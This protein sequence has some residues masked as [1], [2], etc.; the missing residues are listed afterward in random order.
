MLRYFLGNLALIVFACPVS[1]QVGLL[2]ESRPAEPTIGAIFSADDIEFFEK[3]VRPIL[4]NRC[5]ECH[6]SKMAQPKGGLRLDSRAAAIRGGDTGSSVAPGNAKGSLLIDAINYGDLYQMP[7]KNRLPPEEIAILTKWVTKGAPWSKEAISKAPG[8]SD[9]NLQN[10]RDSHWAWR[11]ITHAPL[12]TVADMVWPQQPCDHFVL[13]QLEAR[14]LRPADAASRSTLVRRASFDLLGL[15]PSTEQ[16]EAFVKDDRPDAW[17]RLMDP[18]LAS[19]RMGERWARHW[20]DLMRYAETCGHEFDYAIRNAFYY[21]D[22]VIRAFNSDLPFDQFA[23]EHIAG[24]LLPQ[25]R[26]HPTQGYNES[27]LGTTSWYLGE[28]IHA[29]VD[30]RGD[31]ANRMENQIDVFSKTF[32]GMTVACARCHDHK[33]DAISQKDYY[34]LAGF[35]R[36]S[37]R[38]ETLLDPHGT[39]HQIAHQMRDVKKN[40]D[41]Q[42]RSAIPRDTTV[43]RSQ[44]ASYLRAAMD[45]LQKPRSSEVDTVK[46][47]A[48]KSGLE[49]LRLK[50]WIEA[51]E[52]ESVRH[53]SHPLSL[54]VTALQAGGDTAN[55]LERERAKLQDPRLVERDQTYPLF[56]T[57][58]GPSWNDWFASGEAFGAGPTQFDQW[59]PRSEGVQALRP[60]VGH[61]GALA[62]RLQGVLRS[63]TFTIGHPNIYLRVAGQGAE[64]RLIVDGYTMIEFHQ[65]LF[66]G[67]KFEVKTNGAFGWHRLSGDLNKYIGHRAHFEFIDHGDGYVAIDEIR[68]SNENSPPPHTNPIAAEILAGTIASSLE[69]LA[70]AYATRW[71]QLL[72]NW[73]MSTASAAEVDWLNWALRE[74]LVEL[75]DIENVPLTVWL[76]SRAK[77]LDDLSQKTPDPVRVP[78]ITDG[79]GENEHIHIRGNHRTMGEEAPRQMI[80][81]LVGL[82]PSIGEGSGRL[83]L[84]QDVV[85][86]NNPLTSRVLVNRIWQRLLGRGIVP[87]VDNFGLLG[88]APSHP[89]LLDWLAS[90]FQADGWSIK[91][92]ARRLML[93]STYQLSS[94][95]SSAAE[96]ADPTNRWLQRAAIRRLEGEVL[97]DSILSVSGRLDTTMYGASVPVEITPF[98]QGRGRPASSGPVDG[99]GRRSI[100]VEVRRNFLA[101]MMM[102]F[103]TPIPFTTVG[104][105]NESNVPAQALI[106]LNDPFVMDQASLWAAA[107][108]RRGGSEDD[109]VQQLYLEA[110]ARLPSAPELAESL[111]FLESQG[112]EYGLDREKA[113]RDPRVWADLCHM[114]INVKDFIFLN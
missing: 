6:H 25:P 35:I 39:I 73:H 10:R 97:R 58:D 83:M 45:H 114:L 34:A 75:R 50:K 23:T 76:T 30:V 77:L 1:G 105:R 110:F 3:E 78:T 5:W 100:Y 8:Q 104:K 86:E 74:G 94:A 96:E 37:R 55:C 26:L 46:L 99:A 15:P 29:P 54:W 24:D 52:S 2:D 19:P 102:A 22:Y 65:L 111:A 64:V 89:Q 82:R 106:L 62:P 31:Y 27:I 79:S 32:L 90:S 18:L 80:E 12:P 36:S 47:L 38:Q 68:F 57:L 16:V 17:D 95:S 60:G 81:A 67:L 61:S 66:G 91:R 21:R 13:E 113:R 112:R 71:A 103:D 4:A 14:E 98:M 53:P 93:S 88:E 9:F 42:F 87:T 51:L 33:F 101:P 48:A 56:A 107:V 109:A 11:P 59:D 28:S 7:P 40:A 72:R 92:T 84:A 85:N 20:L 41:S 49:V 69:E 108:L 44:F 43:D 70:Q 63:P